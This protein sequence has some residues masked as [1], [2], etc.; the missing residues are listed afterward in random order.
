MREL[1]VDVVAGS[2]PMAEAGGVRLRAEA[3]HALTRGDPAELA[4][5]LANLVVNSMRHTPS[6]GT[7][8][9]TGGSDGAEVVNAVSDGCGGIAE[10]DLERVFDA[11]WRGSPAR[12]PDPDGGAGLGL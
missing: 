10:H 9:V 3:G 6:D 11:G 5:V 4:R 8:Q 7:V 2:L 1:V 12:T